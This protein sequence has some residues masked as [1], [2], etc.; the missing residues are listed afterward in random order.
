MLSIRTTQTFDRWYS[1]L[2]DNAA[3]IRIQVRI[4]RMLNGNPGDVKAL[5]G[6]IFAMR[7]DHGPGYR[8]YIQRRGEVLVVLLCGGNKSTQ[9]AD[10]ERARHLAVNLDLE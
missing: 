1:A 9:R 4:D 3:R 5:G 10:I 7:V 6:G 8:I 2:R